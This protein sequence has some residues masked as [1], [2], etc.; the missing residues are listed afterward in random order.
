MTIVA[1]ATGVVPVILAWDGVREFLPSPKSAILVS[2]FPTLLDLAHYLNDLAQNETAYNEYLEW[3]TL[4]TEKLNPNFLRLIHDKSWRYRTF[5]DLCKLV[6]IYKSDPT[7][8]GPRKRAFDT[9]KRE[10]YYL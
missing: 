1:F 3:R 10:Y 8:L 7:A 4:P 2:D 9:E 6:A 5:C